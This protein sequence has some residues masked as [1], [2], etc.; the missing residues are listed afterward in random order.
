MFIEHIA[1]WCNNLEEMKSFY[2]KWF[3]A[4]ANNIYH[5]HAKNMLPI[6]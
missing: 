2:C 5:N 1:I 4:T 3:N 6:F